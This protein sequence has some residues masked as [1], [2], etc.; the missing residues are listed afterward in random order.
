[1]GQGDGAAHGGEQRL[2]GR[3]RR[4]AAR[5][6]RPRGRA[7]GD[8]DRDPPAQARLSAGNSDQ[9]TLGWFSVP[10]RH[11][12][13]EFPMRKRTITFALIA[14]VAGATGIVAAAPKDQKP[15]DTSTSTPR[16]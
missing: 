7:A 9:A 8:G 3:D 1:H 5:L 15:S 11:E 12:P 2:G 10:K 13:R 4:V 16:G 6:L 14:A